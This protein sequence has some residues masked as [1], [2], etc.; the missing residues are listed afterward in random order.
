[1]WFL[2]YSYALLVLVVSF[3]FFVR[4]PK[5]TFQ[6]RVIHNK[7]WAFLIV[8]LLVF[9]M[10]PCLVL[11]PVFRLFGLQGFLHKNEIKMDAQAFKYVGNR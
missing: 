7:M 11:H 2:L 9:I 5:I 1:M 3:I 4:A 10:I 6:K 8:V